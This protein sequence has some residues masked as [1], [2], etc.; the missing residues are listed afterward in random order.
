M[1][2]VEGIEVDFPSDYE[3]RLINP[4]DSLEE[5]TRLLHR[6][7]AVLA[8]MGLRYFATYQSIEDT[9]ERI[10]DAAC[11]LVMQQNKIIAT[12]TINFHPTE[13]D[14]DYYRDPKVAVMHQFAVEPELQSTGIGST[15]LE[16]SE[17]WVKKQ[18][19]KNLAL[20]TSEKAQHLIDYY[21]KRGYQEVD[22]IQWEITNYKSVI[23]SKTL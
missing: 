3:I 12:I 7:Y 5:L 6:A 15:L 9:A 20:D 14:P 18:G 23:L 11:W 13:Y 22:S 16:F 1:L 10:R 17:N 2:T 19:I 8:D 21:K 4:W